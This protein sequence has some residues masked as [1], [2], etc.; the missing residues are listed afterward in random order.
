MLNN[1]NLIKTIFWF[2]LSIM[3]IMPNDL[4]YAQDVDEEGEMVTREVNGKFVNGIPSALEATYTWKTEEDFER[5][6]RFAQRYADS[7]GLGYSQNQ[8]S[9]QSDATTEEQA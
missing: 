7:N 9:D 5:F 8:K 1:L 2:L 3:I 6:M 4:I